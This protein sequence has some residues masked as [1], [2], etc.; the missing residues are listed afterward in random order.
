MHAGVK[1]F[2]SFTLAVAGNVEQQVV[3]SK[4]FAMFHVFSEETLVK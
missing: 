3:G 4:K 1:K 2:S